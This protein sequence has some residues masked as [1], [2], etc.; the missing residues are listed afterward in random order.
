MLPNS[1]SAL[2]ANDGLASIPEACQFL[3]VSRTTIDRM[4]AAGQLPLVTLA[5]KSRRIP[6]RALRHLAGSLPQQS[7]TCRDC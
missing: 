2:A 3:R 1:T 4:I 7:E 5:R 6:W